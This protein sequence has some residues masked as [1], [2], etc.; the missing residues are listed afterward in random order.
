MADYLGNDPTPTQFGSYPTRKRAGCDS[1]PRIRG[2]SLCQFEE[3]TRIPIRGQPS[4]LSAPNDLAGGTVIE[5]NH[6]Q[7]TRH[8]FDGYVPE[9]LRQ[10]R[11]QQHIRRCEMTRQVLPRPSPG[12]DRLR[13][14]GSDPIAR[15][16]IT[17]QHQS[18]I[19]R[20][21]GHPAKRI[22]EQTQ[23]FFRS[24]TTHTQHDKRV[25]IRFP[26]SPQLPAPPPRM[27][28]LRI[29]ATP[30]DLQT[31]KTAELQRSGQCTGRNHRA[32]RLIVETP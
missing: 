25:I 18:N 2:N 6:T 8:G 31:F 15:R 28:E 27:E 32:R 12:Q 30:D 22:A 24:K 9:C 13:A 10:A 14:T 17:H 29:H 7:T 1:A 5:G 23:I 4:C 26:G 21:F 3:G 19:P 11:E 16:P 20:R